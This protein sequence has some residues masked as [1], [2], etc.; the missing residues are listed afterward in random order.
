[1]TGKHK[2][3]TLTGQLNYSA[4]EHIVTMVKGKNGPIECVILPLESNWIEKTEKDGKV[5]LHQGIAV[6]DIAPEKQKNGQTHT[7]K[8][9]PKKE[10]KE[11]L[12]AAGKYTPFLGNLKDWSAPTAEVNTSE[13]FDAGA[14]IDTGDDLPF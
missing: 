9:N 12:K 6:Y 11:A 2:M 8:I 1:M 7:I 3:S 13:Q 10:I 4:M 5:Y 14:P